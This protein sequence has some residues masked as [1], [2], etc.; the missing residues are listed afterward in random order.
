[1]SL[2][3]IQVGNASKSLTY[4]KLWTCSFVFTVKNQSDFLI[5]KKTNIILN[6]TITIKMIGYIHML[7]PSGRST[8]KHDRRDETPQDHL[9][10]C[11]RSSNHKQCLHQ[12]SGTFDSHSNS[13]VL[14]FPAV[15]SLSSNLRFNDWIKE[16]AGVFEFTT[17][18]FRG[19]LQSI[20]L[21]PR[22]VWRHLHRVRE[23]EVL[24][25]FDS[26]IIPQLSLRVGVVGCVFLMGFSL[27]NFSTG[28]IVRQFH[29]LLET[30]KSLLIFSRDFIN[31]MGDQ[32]SSKCLHL[33][34]CRGQFVWILGPKTTL[35][36]LANQ[37]CMSLK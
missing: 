33:S 6:F 14:F 9:Q 19:R 17:E 7:F 37:P 10:E 21:Q 12:S 24:R 26:L 22:K 2:L 35:M 5:R 28:V 29:L 27:Y 15:Q 34:L 31:L 13:N 1:M 30:D 18:I 16:N 32:T 23:V 11:D 3:A 8:N 36:S 25:L 20:T 4:Q